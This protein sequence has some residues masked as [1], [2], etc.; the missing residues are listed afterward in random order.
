MQQ[1]VP[2]PLEADPASVDTANLR[3]N[4][5]LADGALFR[6]EAAA[7]FRIMELIRAYGLPIKA[8]CGGAGICST[9]HIR[10]PL[11]WHDHLPPAS[12]DELARLDE[13][14]GADDTSRLAC[15]LMM[16]DD[17]DGLELEVQADSLIPQT[18][19]VAG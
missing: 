4:V 12:D 16:T 15:Q 3:L 14:P 10:I 18:H 1:R 17:L 13:I 7:G 11:A 2:K 19:W 8:E 6:P 9:C 5:R